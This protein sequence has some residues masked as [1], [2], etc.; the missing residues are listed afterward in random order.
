MPTSTII[1]LK[2]EYTAGAQTAK[3]KMLGHAEKRAT[4]SGNYSKLDVTLGNIAKC[5]PH[6]PQDLRNKHTQQR[7]Q[8]DIAVFWSHVFIQYIYKTSLWTTLLL[9]VIFWRGQIKN[10]KKNIYVSNIAIKKNW[11]C[12]PLDTLIKYGL[13]I[14]PWTCKISFM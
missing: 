7:Q 2:K 5:V 14:K 6:P 10:E 1:S 11:G 4:W 8:G 13:T 9:I 3:N 12:D